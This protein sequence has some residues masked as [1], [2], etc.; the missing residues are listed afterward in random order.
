MAA[1]GNWPLADAFSANVSSPAQKDLFARLVRFEYLPQGVAGGGSRNA[2]NTQLVVNKTQFAQLQASSPWALE[3]FAIF[4]SLE[5]MNA[6]NRI[7][8]DD[9]S[10][11]VGDL[12][13]FLEFPAPVFTPQ[14]FYANYLTLTPAT[15][16]LWMANQVSTQ[17][18]FAQQ[19]G[20]AQASYAGRV[21]GLQA[22]L[23]RSWLA[24]LAGDNSGTCAAVEEGWALGTQV[25]RAGWYPASLRVSYD[26]ASDRF[27]V[28]MGQLHWRQSY[29][30]KL[31][32]ITKVRFE[33]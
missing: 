19:P 4:F 25:E 24:D 15:G 11:C 2:E 8:C 18:V 33:L 21:T 14:H 30:E 1:A 20:H 31:D 7:V 3:S 9:V 10:P 28:A 32:A 13:P 12:T 6:L 16:T 29:Q 5:E 17:S 23:A 26:A 22:Q 27:T